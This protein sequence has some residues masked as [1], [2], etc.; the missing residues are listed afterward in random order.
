MKDFINLGEG[1]SLELEVADAFNIK[2]R[3]LKESDPTLISTEAVVV[4]S[5]RACRNFELDEGGEEFSMIEN[6][7]D[8]ASRAIQEGKEFAVV[9]VNEHKEAMKLSKLLKAAINAEE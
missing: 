4:N 1:Y 8:F 6:L 9:A 7:Q 3:V 2:F 5:H